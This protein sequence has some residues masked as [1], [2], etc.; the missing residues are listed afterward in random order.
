MAEQKPVFSVTSLM[1][2]VLLV[3]TGALGTIWSGP[4]RAD[5]QEARNFVRHFGDLSIRELTDKSLSEK[6]LSLRF[7]QLYRKSFDSAA[8]AAFVMGR[9]WRRLSPDQQAEFIDLFEKFVIGNYA[10]RFRFY[11]GET[12]NII[13]VRP[14]GG[15]VF[16]VTGQVRRTIDA[17]PIAVEWRVGKKG[18][19]YKFYDITVEGVSMA[20]T[21]RAEFASVIKNNGGIDGL[22][23]LLRTKT[24]AP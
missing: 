9:H 21:Q 23:A 22:I 17:P 4:V 11:K 13:D 12:F 15:D 6:E 7:E 18:D 2:A 16:L 8:I 1:A 14:E 5:S 19:A 3:L 20:I 24:T 10:Q